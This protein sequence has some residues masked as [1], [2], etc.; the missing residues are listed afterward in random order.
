[1]TA[2]VG[3]FQF[4]IEEFKDAGGRLGIETNWQNYNVPRERIIMKL[5][6]LVNWMENNY[7]DSFDKSAAEIEKK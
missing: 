5:R 3:K 2:S 1:M 4:T 6:A 7:F